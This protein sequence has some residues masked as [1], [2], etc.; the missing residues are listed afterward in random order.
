[1]ADTMAE[2][3]RAKRTDSG[4]WKVERKIGGCESCGKPNRWQT[5]F[6]TY[7]LLPSQQQEEAAR[8]VAGL[9]NDL[10]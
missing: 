4:Y 8:T 2:K 7:Q 1:M 9:L 5:L 6:Y 3:F 10:E